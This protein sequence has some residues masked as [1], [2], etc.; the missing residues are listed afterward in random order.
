VRV[1]DES[2]HRIAVQDR[3][4][5][6]DTLLISGWNQGLEAFAERVLSPVGRRRR[7][8]ASP[9]RRDMH[10]MQFGVVPPC[11]HPSLDQGWSRAI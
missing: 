5:N 9:T 11:E 7:I 2:L 6:L 10:D 4:P 1:F 8:P 3:R